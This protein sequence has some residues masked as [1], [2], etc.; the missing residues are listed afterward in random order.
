MTIS[1]RRWDIFGIFFQL[2]NKYDKI[3]KELG[4]FWNILQLGNKYDKIKRALGYFEAK[5]NNC[6]T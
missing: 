4:C 2:G 5:K 6:M 3:I 1:K